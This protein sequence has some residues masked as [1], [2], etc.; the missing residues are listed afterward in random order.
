VQNPP[1]IKGRDVTDFI[2]T[3]VHPR[4]LDLTFLSK[5]NIKSASNSLDLIQINVDLEREKKK[6]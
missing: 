2:P 3:G 1:S 6:L 5:V 4:E